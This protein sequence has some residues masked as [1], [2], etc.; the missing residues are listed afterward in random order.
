MDW[1][2]VLKIGDTYMKNNKWKKAVEI[3][4][5]AT[6]FIKNAD[7]STGSLFCKL[8]DETDFNYTKKSLKGFFKFYDNSNVK[9]KGYK[10]DGN[11]YVFD[12]I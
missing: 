8:K 10:L 3:F 1:T 7:C 2:I 6:G 4:C 9:V 12:F 11:N 5:N